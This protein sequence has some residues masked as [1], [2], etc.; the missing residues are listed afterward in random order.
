MVQHL[1]GDL[2][3]DRAVYEI[4]RDTRHFA[5]RQLT[6][7][8]KM[9]NRMTLRLD[10]AETAQQI[11]EKVLA[12]V[13]LGAT[14]LLCAL[15]S[16]WSPAPASASNEGWFQSGVQQYHSGRWNEA[17]GLFEKLLLTGVDLKTQKRTR[18]LLGKIYIQQ[19]KYDQAKNPA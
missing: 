8:R 1:E 3:L 19:E 5:K 2:P 17:Q 11:K 15:L 14:L 4:K 6:W 12:Q 10:P 18:F 7:F 16:L 13:P 9:A